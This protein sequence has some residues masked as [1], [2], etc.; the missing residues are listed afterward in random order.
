MIPIVEFVLG[1]A[2]LVYCAEKLIGQLVGVASRWAISLFLIAVVFTGIE[3]DDLAFGVVLNVEGLQQVALGTVIGTTIAMT[4]IVLALA[5]IVAPCRVDVPRDYLVLFVAAPVVMFAL[6]LTGVLTLVTG[7]V[8]VVL[9]V[10]FVGWIGYREYSSR[11]PVFRNAELYEQLEK[12][13]AGGT[14]TMTATG[15]GDTP[16][17]GAGGTTDG[18]SGG[19]TGSGG[20]DLPTDLRIDQG[21]LKA[22]RQSRWGGLGLAVLALAGLVVGAFVAARGTDGILDTFDIAG[23]V[24]GVTIATL[25]LSLEDIF[26]TVE[27]ARRGAPEIGVANVI[28][29]VVFSVTGKLGIV[30]LVGGVITIGDD[31]LSWHLPV[32][33]AMTALSAIFLATGRLR[34]WHG[35][36]LLALYV[37]YFVVSLVV[38][39]EVPLDSD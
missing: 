7:V 4:G 24:F 6:A 26:L 36:V 18:G 35:I 12:V 13:G 17:G 29:S 34:R 19:T 32:M 15:G 1:I 38:F 14:A 9:F 21:F 31:V 22:R 20:F 30:L 37:A 39:G 16:A 3:F 2:V 25:A 5:A 27:P 10:A 28:G 33:L 8:L 11:R 23:T